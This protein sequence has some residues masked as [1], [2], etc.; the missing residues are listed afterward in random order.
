MALGAWW[1]HSDSRAADRAHEHAL[2]LWE[3]KE[4]T[5]Y[6]FEYS[7]CGGM[8]AGCLLQVTVQNGKVIDAVGVEGQCGSRQA[9]TIEG[10]F[11]MEKADRAA[12]T[13]DSFTIRYDPTWGFPVSVDIRCPRGWS[14]CGSGYHVRDF[15]DL[16]RTPR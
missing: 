3:S 11:A 4:P 10:I 1:L 12:S 7:R 9:P 2:A 13:T 8:C 15:H 5:A 14:D 16:S 6:S